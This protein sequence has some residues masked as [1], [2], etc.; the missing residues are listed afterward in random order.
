MDEFQ[1]SSII[2]E[3]R[4]GPFGFF[5]G[6]AQTKALLSQPDGGDGGAGDSS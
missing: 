6:P 3:H 5:W 2:V 4:V 1:I